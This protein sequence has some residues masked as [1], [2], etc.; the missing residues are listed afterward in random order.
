MMTELSD[1]QIERYLMRIGLGGPL[2]STAQTLSAIQWAHLHTVPFENLEI[3]PL[4]R[5]FTLDIPAVYE[6]VVELNGLLAVLLE[7]LGFEVN[8]MAAH[9]AD[10]ADPDPF[11]HLVLDVTVPTDGSRWYADVGA[12]R[13]NPDRA[14]P[15]DGISA[16]GQRRV[17]LV[18]GQWVAER[19]DE[20]GSWTPILSWGP[21]VHELG[22]F[23]PRCTYFQT[24]PDSFFRSGAMCSML[25]AGGR[26]TLVKRTLITTINGEREEREL[27]ANGEIA[28]ALRSI[29]GIEI[30]VDDRWR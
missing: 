18:D 7:S 8:R 15:I 28:D 14:I 11:D 9:F 10:A 13:T 30:P 20:D 6:K 27:A 29:F 23:M 26:A 12:G 19:V 3:C 22:A 21:E 5:R 4:D 16:E 2:P 17:H 25:V 24:H 1:K